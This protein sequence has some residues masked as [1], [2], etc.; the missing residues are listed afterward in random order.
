MKTRLK[1]VIT[2]LVDN[3]I[4]YGGSGIT[5]TLSLK[6]TLSTVSIVTVAD[7]GPGIHLKIKSRFLS[8]FTGAKKRSL[9]RGAGLGLAVA[10]KIIDAHQ[11]SIKVKSE[12]GEG[13]TFIISLPVLGSS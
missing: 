8:G 3:A 11:G 6:T 10:K 2:I 9:A 1:Q 12:P 5:I 13:T 4:K 7:T